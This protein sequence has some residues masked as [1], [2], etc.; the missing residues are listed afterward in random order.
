MAFWGGYRSLPTGEAPMHW[1]DPAR[2]DKKTRTKPFWGLGNWFWYPRPLW[3]CTSMMESRQTNPKCTYLKQQKPAI[4]VVVYC[5]NLPSRSLGLVILVGSW[6]GCY[7]TPNILWIFSILHR[8]YVYC[9]YIYILL[10][11]Q[12]FWDIQSSIKTARFGSWN[13]PLLQLRNLK[14]CSS[15]GGVK[16]GLSLGDSQI[17]HNRW[18]YLSLSH[19]TFI[20]ARWPETNE[21]TWGWSCSKNIKW[22]KFVRF[23]FLQSLSCLE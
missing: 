19:P 13:H 11:L 6:P 1:S 12:L 2:P 23:H 16:G 15:P 20:G 21:G 7:R 22:L 4:L 5:Q 17:F 14:W 3:N 10:G 9:M 18:T 8:K